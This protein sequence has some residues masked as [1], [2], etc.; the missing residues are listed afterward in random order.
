LPR[1]DIASSAG[2]WLT[3]QQSLD[4]VAVATITPGPVVIAVVFIGYLVAAPLGAI[5][6]SIGVFTPCFFIVVLATRSSKASRP[7]R[8]AQFASAVV[9]LAR[10]SLVDPSA[11]GIAL[12]SLFDSAACEEAPGPL[13][14][15]G[16]TLGGV[17]VKELRQ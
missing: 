7:G 12:G 17:A 14:I 15:L 16:V 8:W 2:L 1:H 3:E 9:V 4:A 5:L 6:A 13:L 10:K 11:I